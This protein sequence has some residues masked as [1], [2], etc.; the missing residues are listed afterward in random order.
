LSVV[1]V[2]GA[3]LLTRSLNKLEHQDFGFQT[4]N[5]ITVNL[6]SPP[7]TYTPQR[8]DALYRN[9]QDRLNHLPGVEGASLSLYNPFTDNWSEAILVP[10]HPVPSMSENS[11]ASLDRVSPGYFQVVGQPI[12][13]GRDF[14][15]ADDDRTAPIAI[16]NQAFVQRFFPKEDP[17]DKR[18]GIDM[19]AYAKTFRII[20]IVRDAKFAGFALRQPA[21]PMFYVPLAQNVNYADKDIKR[22][23]LQSHFIGGMLLV[24]NVPPGIL[25]PRLKRALAAA[26]PDLTINSV[27]TLDDQVALSFDQERAVTSLASLFGAVALILAAVGLYG[28]TAYTVAQRTAEIGIRIAV[29]ADRPNVVL[30]VL[31]DA[32]KRVSL[33]LI[34]GL[35][36]AV[37]C[38]KLIAAQLYGVPFW[39]PP[40]LVTATI[41]LAVCAF[42]AAIIPAQRAASISPMQAL[43]AE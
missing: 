41:A 2:A 36:L 43:R 1:L 22:I 11:I 42:T 25:E 7:A 29:G 24:T 14:T 5:R 21:R 16:V 35:P 33:G 13:R 8:V 34:A 20:G 27:R 6:N 17:M 23:E 10:G 3:G 32:F 12:L 31:Q 38:G 18:F 4:A 9:L 26:N 39:D 40:A 37:L 30:L 28:L 15:E 19:P